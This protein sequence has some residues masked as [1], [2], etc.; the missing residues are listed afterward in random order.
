[1]F[2]VV[3]SVEDV[4]SM[5]IRGKLIKYFSW[6]L[7][8]NWKF[9]GNE[10]YTFSDRAVL[11]TINKYHLYFDNIDVKVRN[12]LLKHIPDLEIDTVIFASKH[13]SAS[14]MKTLTVH[15]IGNFKKAEYGGKHEELVPA[16]PHAMTGALRILCQ[17]AHELHL[18]HAITFEATHH[19]PYLETPSFFIEI[20]SDE[21]AWNDPVAATAI[22]KTIMNTL[23]L[24]IKDANT[25]VA[26][27]IGGG[28]YAPRHSDVVRKKHVSFGH[29]IPS[30]ALEGINDKMLSMAVDRTP[31]IKFIYFHRKAMKKDRYRTLKSWFED[32]DQVVISSDDLEDLR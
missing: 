25:P 4:A 2:L 27:G 19:G 20:G 32:A 26:I 18:D 7:Q 13:R 16:A 31:N 10:V 9:D 29:I 24:D 17:E 12:E 28:H 15:P 1:M 6:E 21:S 14:G 3:I 5:N 30:Y 23:E 11:V 8:K 22:A